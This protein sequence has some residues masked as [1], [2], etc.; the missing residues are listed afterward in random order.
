MVNYISTIHTNIH[1]IPIGK[2]SGSGDIV[3]FFLLLSL[4][5]IV[6]QT[7]LHTLCSV[8]LAAF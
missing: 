8:P 5:W 2:V 7:R 3:L 1:G 4:K 6:L